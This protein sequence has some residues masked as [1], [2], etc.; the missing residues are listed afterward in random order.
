MLGLPLV[1]TNEIRTDVKAAFLPVHALKDPQLCDKLGTMLSAGTPVLVTDGLA[2]KLPPTLTDNKN[3]LVLKVGGKP[4]D[5]LDLTREQLQPIR[6][7]LL[8]PFGLRFDAPNK[9]ALYLIG[10][11]AAQSRTS[12]MS[13][14]R[15]PWNSRSIQPGRNRSWRPPVAKTGFSSTPGRIDIR[16]LPARTLVVVEGTNAP[17]YLVQ[18]EAKS[19]P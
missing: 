3:L 5:L 12:T 14:L 10:G 7:K 4:K 2:R 17:L 18:S 8:A 1:P 11:G 19:L 9:V 16:T 15:C 6:D 13:L